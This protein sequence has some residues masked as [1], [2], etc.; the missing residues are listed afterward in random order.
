VG[1]IV[2][3][4]VER[5]MELGWDREEAEAMMR[6]GQVE[7]RVYVA[8][9]DGSERL[10]EPSDTAA[11]KSPDGFAWGYG[12]SGPTALA[13]SILADIVGEDVGMVLTPGIVH[14]FKREFIEPLDQDSGFVVAESTIREWLVRHSGYTP[15][16]AEALADPA[17][18]VEGMTE[19]R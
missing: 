7:S 16:L 3:I 11:Q 12:G 1:R 4:S 18:F 9:P 10:L 14:D 13:M 8:E 17:G 6:E 19:A 5:W 2:P 15:S